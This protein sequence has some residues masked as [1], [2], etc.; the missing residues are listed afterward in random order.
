MPTFKY[1]AKTNEGKTITGTVVASQPSEVVG[2]LRKKNL[3]VL[4]V[5]ETSRRASGGGATTGPR[6]QK[7]AAR[8]GN[9]KRASANPAMAPKKTQSPVETTAWMTLF[10][11]QRRTGYSKTLT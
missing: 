7:I 11:I 8:P 4:D 2:E 1:A 3:V 5:Q 6:G 10:S 9:L